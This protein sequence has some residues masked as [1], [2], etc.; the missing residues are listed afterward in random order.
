MR[1]QQSAMT[2]ETE[3]Q[4]ATFTA[5]RIKEILAFFKSISSFKGDLSAISAPPFLLCDISFVEFSQYW[6]ER[7]SLF[8]APANVT[9]PEKRALGVLKWFL[10]TLKQQYG[11]RPD[12]RKGKPLNPF[13]GELFLGRWQGEEGT[14]EL[15]A[16]Q[17]SH[18]PPVTAFAVRNQTH[19][20]T[21]QGYNAQ[22][23]TF[24]RTIRMRRFGHAMLHLDRYDE[25]YQIT[26]PGFHL[27]GL[28]PPPPKME[29]DNDKP[30]YIVSSSGFTS[31]ITYSGKG[32]LR[33]KRNCFV[34]EMYRTD[35]EKAVLYTAEGQWSGTFSINDAKGKLL[36][37]FDTAAAPLC[38]IQVAPLADQDELESRKAWSSVAAAIH[39]GNMYEISKEKAKLEV[40]Q[41]ELRKQEENEGRQ[42]ERRF[43]KQAQDDEKSQKL[44]AA[45][46]LELEPDK[47]SGIWIWNEEKH[48]VWKSS[49]SLPN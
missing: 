48:H 33:G 20:V 30:T 12:R 49:R 40:S 1:K 29:I 24:E 5:S 39:K 16:E 34:A 15:V 2:E 18:H 8:V 28:I 21:L 25:D 7:P 6:A 37:T 43:F 9:S 31:R 27:E 38:T 19:G 14:T 47:T 32:W 45:V 22:K 3:P 42:Y 26:F 36:E 10:S 13:L 17:V 4:D 23:M 46:G 41:R 11:H 35:E 44:L